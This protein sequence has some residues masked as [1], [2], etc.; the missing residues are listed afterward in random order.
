M[1]KACNFG[2]DVS[3]TGQIASVRFNRFRNMDGRM[4]DGQGSFLLEHKAN[5]QAIGL[6][7]L[8]QAN[9]M[10]AWNEIINLPFQSQAED[11]ISSYESGGTAQT[12]IQIHDNYVQGDYAAD[13]AGAIDFSGA[14]INLGDSPSCDANVGYT[15]A[16]NNQ[17]VSFAFE[18]G[19]TGTL[20]MHGHSSVEG[21]AI[22]IDGSKA[23]L[24]GIFR[25]DRQE[26]RIEPHDLEGMDSGR[27]EVIELDNGTDGHGGGD[28]GLS[29]AFVRAV[30]EQTREASSS[31]LESHLLAFAIE[32]ARLENR[33]VNMTE[34][35]TQSAQ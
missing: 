19:G 11:V 17:V 4:S 12:P 23:T 8:R 14:G 6:N 32:R 35:R 30:L 3:R 34:F 13:P 26:I 15:D 20:T 21:R 28:A 2:A 29:E 10:I 1:I 31:I 25:N 5:G 9:V 24:R 7:T 33:V 27:G 18:D 22:R 16:Y